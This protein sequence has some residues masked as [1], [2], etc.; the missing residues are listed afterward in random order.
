M[1]R[2]PSTDLKEDHKPL[3][4]P[5]RER[6]DYCISKAVVVFGETTKTYGAGCALEAAIDSWNANAAPVAFDD[7]A[8]WNGVLTWS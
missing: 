3:W 1:P 4:S 6:K 2:A 7:A 5:Q 8:F